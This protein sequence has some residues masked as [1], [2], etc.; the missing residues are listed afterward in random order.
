MLTAFLSVEANT[1]ARR[2]ATVTLRERQEFEA[3]YKV[4]IT[5]AAFPAIEF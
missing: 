3:G 1:P 4:Q 5:S 2:S